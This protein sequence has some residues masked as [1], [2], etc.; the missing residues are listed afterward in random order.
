MTAAPAALHLPY[1]HYPFPPRIHPETDQAENDMIDWLTGH[2]LL[3]DPDRETAFRATRFAEL[4]GREYPD[5]DA[6]G[7]RVVANFYG[8]LFIVDDAVCDT[9]ALGQNL[10]K[11]ATF[12][13]WLRE[14]MEVGSATAGDG[15]ARAVT[16]G[17]DEVDRNMCHRLA[18]AGHD[19]F[20]SIADRSS[21]TQYMRFAAGMDYY[22]LGTLWEAGQHVRATTPSPAEYVVGR[23][24]TSGDPPGLAL[25]DI[26]AGYEVPP[27][28]YQH[29]A[30]RELRR[31]VANINCWADDVF[32]YGK[33]RDTE[34]PRSLNLPNSLAHHHGLDEQAALDETARLHNQE[35]A[36]YLSAEA[37]VVTW[38]SPELRRF[39]AALHDMM[40]GFYDWGPKTP[41]YNVDH[42]FGTRSW[43][44]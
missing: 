13:V 30:V 2:G 16:T 34:G 36:A 8:W 19:L 1:L 4:V 27:D 32:S 38:A 43:T 41:R 26:T 3:T 29:P 17:L 14:I 28:E 31:H 22:F 42:Y 6:D 44:P 35:M 7:L 21:H 10:A 23:R 18:D 20:R 5:A 9:G 11:L 25:H 12:H 39:L 37:K 40:R 33:E 15:P 24:M